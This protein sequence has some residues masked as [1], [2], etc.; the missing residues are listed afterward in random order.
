MLWM[1]TLSVRDLLGKVNILVAANP[2]SLPPDFRKLPLKLWHG[3]PVLATT[4]WIWMS[5]T[6]S[7]SKSIIP[8]KMLIFS[9]YVCGLSQGMHLVKINLTGKSE[10]YNDWQ[11]WLVSSRIQWGTTINIIPEFE[12]CYDAQTT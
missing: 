6:L 2:Y 7:E 5:A 11:I 8:W 4:I 3:Q 12:I 1:W 10:T 9:A